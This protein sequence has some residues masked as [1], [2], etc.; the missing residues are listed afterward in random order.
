MKQK[1][2]LK[3]G[4]MIAM[5]LIFITG[6]AKREVDMVTDVEGLDFVTAREMEEDNGKHITLKIGTSTNPLYIDADVTIPNSIKTGKVEQKFPDS[7]LI[8]KALCEGESLEQIGENQWGIVAQ[9]QEYDYE[10]YYEVDEDYAMYYDAA[11]KGDADKADTERD[12]NEEELKQQAQ[13]VLDN[14]EFPAVFVYEETDEVEKS[15][16]FFYSPAI[17]GVPVVSSTSGLGGVQVYISENG[18]SEML[19]EKQIVPDK[20]E[21]TE[22]MSLDAML[23]MLNNYYENGSL[24]PLSGG[25]KVRFIRLAYYVDKQSRLKPVWCFSIDFMNVG[26][27][28]LV[29]CF[30]AEN[31]EIVFD[32]NS[33]TVEG[34]GEE[35]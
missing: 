35:E 27:E 22:V 28:Y 6:C 30:D 2:Q 9:G 32:Y 20:L 33:Y 34:E 1:N 3:T 21:E 18:V 25:D 10:K 11:I 17:E 23:E 29:Y 15:T 31:G 14:C 16:A 24:S 13:Q 5:T 8:E 26:K 7:S 19:L 4:L 12:V